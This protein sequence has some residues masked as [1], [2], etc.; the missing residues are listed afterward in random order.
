MNGDL[1]PSDTTFMWTLTVSNVGPRVKFD[2]IF[3]AFIS[4]KKKKS[5][6]PTLLSLPDLPTPP[7]LL[8]R[9]QFSHQDRSWGSP[10]WGGA[11]ARS[12]TRTGYNSAVLELNLACAASLV[13]VAKAG[14]ISSSLGGG[15][16]GLYGGGARARSPAPL[17]AVGLAKAGWPDLLARA[18]RASAMAELDSAPMLPFAARFLFGTLAVGATA[19]PLFRSPVVVGAARL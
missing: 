13:G 8:S 18:A 2:H 3:L 6:S 9:L 10:G 11:R 16:Q 5:S 4:K 14:Q 19:R 15:G 17:V 12:L 1:T 7:S